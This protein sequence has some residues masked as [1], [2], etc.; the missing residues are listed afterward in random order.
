[1]LCLSVNCSKRTQESRIHV[2]PD[3]LLTPR[4]SE[5]GSR[6]P[7]GSQ[8]SPHC[9]MASENLCSTQ[10][11]LKIVTNKQTKNTKRAF[12]YS[13]PCLV[14]NHNA[15][16]KCPGSVLEDTVSIGDFGFF[17]IFPLCAKKQGNKPWPGGGWKPRPSVLVWKPGVRAC[18]YRPHSCHRTHDK[19]QLKREGFTLALSTEQNGG[20]ELWP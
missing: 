17:I 4:Q 2:P 5:A 7:T 20:T 6:H 18:S 1:M 12:P 11:P 15:P 19:K 13:K 9:T 14:I 8:H 10:S 3:T 16:E